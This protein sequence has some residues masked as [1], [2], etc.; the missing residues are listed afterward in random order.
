M[1]VPPEARTGEIPSKPNSGAQR[2]VDKRFNNGTSSALCSWLPTSGPPPFCLCKPFSCKA[3]P[4][5]KPCTQMGVQLL[6]N[7]PPT[8]VC[9]NATNQ[10]PSWA[11]PLLY[12]H[13]FNRRL[14]TATWAPQSCRGLTSGR[15]LN[16]IKPY[17]SNGWPGKLCIATPQE[18]NALSRAAN[19]LH[20]INCE[21]PVHYFAYAFAHQRLVWT[22]SAPYGHSTCQES[23]N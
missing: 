18:F 5:I 2:A 20:Q 8:C 10:T 11:P 17:S 16:H 6:L 7:G 14:S 3:C 22:A 1:N 19:Q 15:L 9:R 12:G 13:R 4:G 23:A 21:H